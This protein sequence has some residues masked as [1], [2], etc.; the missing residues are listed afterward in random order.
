MALAVALAAA[1]S[2]AAA[3]APVGSALPLRST[4][5]VGAM[6][7]KVRKLL[8]RRGNPLHTSE[9]VRQRS[10]QKIARGLADETPQTR[11]SG[12]DSCFSAPLMPILPMPGKLSPH[13]RVTWDSDTPPLKNARQVFFPPQHPA[14]L[15]CTASHIRFRDAMPAAS[16]GALGMCLG[17]LVPHEIQ[18]E[19]KFFEP[20]GLQ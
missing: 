17:S 20:E 10:W 8:E 2:P 4:R 3:F 14:P 13:E 9:D 6:S 16:I 19:S 1:V 15:P 11:Q 5:S 12:R 18:L 7:V